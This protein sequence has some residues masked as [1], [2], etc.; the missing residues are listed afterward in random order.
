MWGYKCRTISWKCGASW[1]IFGILKGFQVVGVF[2]ICSGPFGGFCYLKK[3]GSSVI[4]KFQRCEQGRQRT[5]VILV[6]NTISSKRES[7]WLKTLLS[8][9]SMG[10]SIPGTAMFG[11]TILQKRFF[12][13]GG[14]YFR[15]RKGCWAR[16]L[17]ADT[18]KSTE[19]PCRALIQRT[20]HCSP[21]PR[22]S[23][24]P[25][26]PHDKDNFKKHTN[27]IKFI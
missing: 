11:I 25:K 23:P 4:G 2:A 13:R 24:G 12:L 5:V 15:C 6:A 17:E 27:L 18:L 16:P 10:P 21:L 8:S 22:A 9:R 19:I 7:G 1:K 14:S 3:V 26:A 20:P